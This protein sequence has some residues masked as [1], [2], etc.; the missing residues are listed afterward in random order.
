MRP[1]R[2]LKIGSLIE[3]ELSQFFLKNLD[4]NGAFVTITGIEVL[5]DLSEA[6]VKISILPEEKIPAVFKLLQKSRRE[7][8]F[9]LLRKINIKPMPTLKFEIAR[10]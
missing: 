10:Y 8:Q 7:I 6:R 1:Y 9:R 4:F 5:E 3:R 2:N